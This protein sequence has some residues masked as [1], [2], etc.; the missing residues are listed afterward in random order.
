MGIR[1]FVSEIVFKLF[2]LLS[3]VAVPISESQKP[4]MM[5]CDEIRAIAMNSVCHR[6]SLKISDIV[7]PK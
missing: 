4:N 2:K 3:S 1:L 7:V 6:D 5:N